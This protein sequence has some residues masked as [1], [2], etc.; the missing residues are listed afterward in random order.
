MT[1]KLEF[2]KTVEKIFCNNDWNIVSYSIAD[3]DSVRIFANK[4]K[5]AVDSMEVMIWTLCESA[6][7]Q[8]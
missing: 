5:K 2:I 8:M 3:E 7:C 4:C 1:S 6:L